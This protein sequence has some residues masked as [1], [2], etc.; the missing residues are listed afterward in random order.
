MKWI[1]ILLVFGLVLV[2]GCIEQQASTNSADVEL[3]ISPEKEL[4]QRGEIIRLTGAVELSY[5]LEELNETIV[6]ETTE[7]IEKRKGKEIEKGETALQSSGTQTDDYVLVS[8]ITPPV[9]YNGKVL[10]GE[11]I[12]IAVLDT[13]VDYTHP[14]LGNCQVSSAEVCQ[15]PKEKI[16]PQGKCTDTDGGENYCY[17]GSAMNKIIQEGG[18]GWKGLRDKCLDA[19]TLREYYCDGE[20][21]KFVD[22]A[23]KGKCS[24]F[25]CV[26]DR[27]INTVGCGKV[28]GGYDFVNDDPDP[29]D[30][31]GHGTHVAGIATGNGLIKGVAPKAKILIY[32]VL[33]SGGHG[34]TSNIQKALEK[35]LDPN[36]DGNYNDKA[37][38]VSMSL[39]KTFEFDSDS[40]IHKIVDKLIDNGVVVVASAGNDGYIGISEGTIGSYAALPKT[41]AI[42]SATL[43]KDGTY[44]VSTFS[45]KGPTVR[46]TIK[47]DVLVPGDKICSARWDSAYDS[48]VL[49]GDIKLC[50]TD[51]GTNRVVLSGTSMAAP[52]VSGAVALIKQAHPNWT[53]E[54]IKSAL[55]LTAKDLGESIFAQGSGLIDIQKAVDFTSVP[56]TGLLD[57]QSPVVVGSLNITGSAGGSDFKKYIVY[58]SRISDNLNFIK[59]EEI[60]TPIS[61]GILTKLDT[62]KLEDGKYLIKLIVES[63]SGESIEDVFFVYILNN[64]WARYIPKDGIGLEMPLAA[65]LDGDGFK[66]VIIKEAGDLA[67]GKEVKINVF[68]SN[69]DI[70]PTSWPVSVKGKYQ[71]LSVADLDG[72]GFK[73]IVGVVSERLSTEDKTKSKVYIWSYRGKLKKTFEFNGPHRGNIIEDVDND[74]ILDIITFSAP[75]NDI[76]ILHIFGLDSKKIE[77]S[78]SVG[79]GNQ[80]TLS[81]PIGPFVADF[82]KD[83]NVEIGSTVTYFV[84]PKG[85]GVVDRKTKLILFDSSGNIIS[86]YPKESAESNPVAVDINNDGKLEIF[87]GDKAYNLKGDVV[88]TY[89]IQSA[90]PDLRSFVVD[91]NTDNKMDI[92][93][94]QKIFDTDGKTIYSTNNTIG[95]IG[96]VDISR[97]GLEIVEVSNKPPEI[98]VKDLQGT[99][100]WRRDLLSGIEYGI[101]IFLTDLENNGKINIIG[102]DSTQIIY[103][104]EIDAKGDSSKGWPALFYNERNTNCLGCYKK[105]TKRVASS[106]IRNKETIPISATLGIKIEKFVDGKW[107]SFREIYNNKIIVNPTETKSLKDFVPEIKIDDQGT[108]KIKVALKDNNGNVLKNKNGEDIE[109]TSSFEIV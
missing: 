73:E 24:A 50:M 42:G 83:G 34:K 56:V 55:K 78:V 30:D 108:Y 18:E 32:K 43:N 70:Y 20:E 51:K 40:P 67:I 62:T 99:V 100:L 2:S 87:V 105:S 3:S 94:D 12:T 28:I 58:Y 4:Y 46:G 13:G 76:Y 37:D 59:I 72:D 92:V 101:H 45:S 33:N 90:R 35:A 86:G 27:D 9:S 29:M 22:Y 19:K 103:N 52:Y 44:S 10:D 80:I 66:E 7:D 54:Q 61:N 39:G 16:S 97:P 107:E 85:L 41:I 21:I 96:E 95:F 17:S 82:D 5:K 69:G 79:D 8:D 15:S 1:F 47:P 38:I 23:C 36:G 71:T 64:K 77:K 102:T 81:G 57:L 75:A 63:G 11:G 53:P 89:N 109:T 98:Y 60:S 49:K 14:D 26:A 93:F 74:G 104:F 106:I 25:T 6:N 48:E 84:Q 88:N 91:V 65:D 68:F 31:Y